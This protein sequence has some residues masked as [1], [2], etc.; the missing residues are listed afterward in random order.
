MIWS[1]NGASSAG[2]SGGTVWRGARSARAGGEAH[3]FAFWPQR[4]T[5]GSVGS[6][7]L[8]DELFGGMYVIS[9]SAPSGNH[10]MDE[11]TKLHHRMLAALHVA[12][13]RNLPPPIAEVD[14]Y[15]TAIEKV[16]IGKM[17]VADD[18]PGLG[19]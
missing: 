2:Q 8:G 1:G 5:S 16:V 4:V 3:V 7:G 9:W 17:P 12:N 6:P 18:A 15:F 14:R 11:L 10:D 13:R 19:S